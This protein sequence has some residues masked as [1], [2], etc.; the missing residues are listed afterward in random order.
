MKTTSLILLCAS[1]A[2]AASAATGF[3]EFKANPHCPKTKINLPESFA[4]KL[5]QR[6]SLRSFPRELRQEASP[7]SFARELHQEA[8]TESFA[9]KLQKKAT[10]ESFARKLRQFIRT[11]Y[12]DASLLRRI[13]TYLLFLLYVLVL[14]YLLFDIFPD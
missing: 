1:L 3:Q 13:N 9:S 4:R 11:N 7:D 8:S 10:P 6:A 12:S 5:R 2:I 14:L